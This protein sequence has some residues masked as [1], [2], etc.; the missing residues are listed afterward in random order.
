MRLIFVPQYPT[1]LRYPEWWIWKFAEEF[2]KAGFDV[3]T[4]RETLREGYDDI[5]DAKR[6]YD[7]SFSPT[8]DAIEF[9]TKQVKYYMNLELLDDD[10]LFLAD[11]SFPGFFPNV[12]H[13]KKPKKCFAFCHATSLNFLDYFERVR[14]S[15]SQVESGHAAMFDKIFVGSRY[16]KNKLRAWKNVEVTYVP[17]PPEVIIKPIKTI[18]KNFILSVSRDTQQKKTDYIEEAVEKK[19]GTTKIC[20]AKRWNT[21]CRDLS[22]SKALLITANEETFGYQ[23]IDALK[24]NCIPVAPNN[25][26]YPELLPQS[27]L[28]DSV[29]ELLE[30]LD[31]IKHDGMMLPKLICETRTKNFYDNI[32]KIMIG[33][34]D[35]PF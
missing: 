26:S 27:C 5:I 24:N 35:Y 29:P 3:L 34:E 13:H 16:H 23:V 4:L 33:G 17:E 1:K 8:T 7:S 19:Y 2:D 25:Y 21:Y 15:K 31:I 22:E 30:I 18:K 11:L 14:F 6:G 9:E 12:L 10:I 32:I 20:N 28:Y